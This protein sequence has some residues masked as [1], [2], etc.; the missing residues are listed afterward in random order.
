[1]VRTRS[2][3][4]SSIVGKLRKLAKA[5]SEKMWIGRTLFALV[6]LAAIG[7]ASFVMGQDG[8]AGNKVISL[9]KVD[10]TDVAN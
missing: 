3:T 6:L 4:R 10:L 7:L 5:G 9:I 8:F 1:M 2:L